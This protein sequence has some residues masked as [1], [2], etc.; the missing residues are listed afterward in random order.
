[1]FIILRLFSYYSPSRLQT[2]AIFGQ[3][4]KVKKIGIFTGNGGVG[5]LGR[6]TYNYGVSGMIINQT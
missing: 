2:D 5:D 3:A 1:M 4:T 6:S